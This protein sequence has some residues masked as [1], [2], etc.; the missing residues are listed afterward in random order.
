MA[1]WRWSCG[2]AGVARSFLSSRSQS[3]GLPSLPLDLRTKLVRVAR[4]FTCHE[5]V[6]FPGAVHRRPRPTEALKHASAFIITLSRR[7]PTGLRIATAFPSLTTLRPRLPRQRSPRLLQLLVRLPRAAAANRLSSRD[8]FRLSE[9][10][11]FSSAM[12]EWRLS[13]KSRRPLRT[14]IGQLAISVLFTC[15]LLSSPFTSPVVP[16]VDTRSEEFKCHSTI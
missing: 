5:A 2:G 13:L 9:S 10:C 6:L 16:S 4:C 1:S 3:A 15:F 12:P 11:S 8:T 14:N 7:S